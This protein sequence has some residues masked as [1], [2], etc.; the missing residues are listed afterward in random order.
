M[1]FIAGCGKCGTTT[2]AHL[3]NNHP[4]IVLSSPKEPN[5]YSKDSEYSRGGGYYQSLFRD[6]ASAKIRLDASVSY[7]LFDT[8]Q[9]VANRILQT[10]KAPKFIYIA[11]NPYQRLESVFSEAHQ[12][13]HISKI[14]MPYDL[15]SAIKYYLPM[16]FNSLYWERTE[17]IRR[18][19]PS[20][21]ILYL[22]LEDLASNQQGVLNRC[23]DFL[24]IDSISS[25]DEKTQ[26]NKSISKTYEPV[27]LRRIRRIFELYDF[28]P[29][30]WLNYFQGK[31]RRP[32]SELDFS[33]DE[34]MRYFIQILF[35]ENVKKYLQAAGKSLSFWGEEFL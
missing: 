2:L 8:E 17:A 1:C 16:V 10:C 34:E 13:T 19:F 9:K 28:L 31:M 29:S 6:K 33:W 14:D 18:S 23:F 20:K 26:M 27:S 24:N 5:F 25:V 30:S 4:A 22:T 15:K 12:H 35:R 7:T 21:D 11:R 32:V 3:M